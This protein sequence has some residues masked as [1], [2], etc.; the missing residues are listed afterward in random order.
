MKSNICFLLISLILFLN[1]VQANACGPYEYYPYGYKMYRVFDKNSIV[2][3]DERT[4]NCILWQKLTSP[5]IPLEDI[6]SVVY[7][8]TL[9]QMRDLMSVQDPNAFATWI[10]TNKDEE[11]YDFLMLAKICENTRG[12]MNDPWYYPSKN[13]GTYMSLIEIEEKAKAYKGTR[14]SDRY[15]LQAVRAMFSAQRYQECIDYWNSVESGL[16]DGLLKEMSRSYLVGAYSRIGQIDIALEYFTDVKDLNSIMFCLRRQGKIKDVADE[17][18]CIAK[19]AP[20][21]YQIPEIL[22]W[23]VTGFEPWG[24]AY[25]TYQE[26]MDT[27]MVN[28]IDKGFFDKLYRLSVQMARQPVSKNK[29]VWC[30]T[31]AFL[32]DLEAKPHEA[33]KYIQMATKCPTSEY[34][35]ESINVLKMYLDA[36]V[37]VYD[38][39]YE[40]RLFNDLKW[41]DAK[42]RSELTEDLRNNISEY[43]YYYLRSNISFYY[44]NDMLRRILLAEVCPRML[45][46]GMETRA[47]QLAN[48]ADNLLLN[49]NDSLEGMSLKEYRL[50][51][52]Y[53]SI[54]YCSE[55]FMM[56]KDSVSIGELITYVN[57][58]QS[59]QSATFDN[60][61]NER[62]FID[63]DYFYDIIGTRYLSEM[64]YE[65]AVKYLS[66]ISSS[67]QSRLN[68]E[69]YMY[70]D[71]FSIPQAALT[72][73]NNYKLTFAE[74]MLRLEKSIASVK[75]QSKKAFDLICYG[76]GL[77]NSVTYCWVL[78]EYRK[79]GWSCELSL[80]VRTIL[81]K[82]ESIYNEALSIVDND[83][84]AAIAYIK[85][86]KWKTAVNKYPDTYAAK[87]TKMMC[88]NLCDY[89]TD[90]VVRTTYD[91][92][93]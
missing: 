78:T 39:A 91:F 9:T 50:S 7:K 55:F 1:A 22:Q 12:L 8:Y 42:I 49:L 70:R 21:S 71:P 84:L 18:E 17:L 5:K 80:S 20:D 48:M 11:I 30:Y 66:K 46:K 31:A 45:D 69:A 85:L 59:G 2:K 73:H 34:M 3:P 4:E 19:Y 64:N 90:W 86:C 15:A 58:T 41:L 65:K 40:S 76:T 57:N 38:S 74:E 37:S 44:W 56:M 61:L 52:D 29:A 33:W 43:Y 62:G 79:F 67:Y 25:Y 16:P 24:A 87:Y 27:T 36:K 23:V 53:N 14:L 28:S 83:E 13:D 51:D 89:R 93:E 88:D 26:R 63:K 72:N 35:K 32:A 47:L 6:E 81:D 82:V 92:Q 54:D 60:Y 75:D 68:T 10:R 77:R